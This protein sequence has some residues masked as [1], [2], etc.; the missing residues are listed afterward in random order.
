MTDASGP[1]SPEVRRGQWGE[2]I[3]WP[4]SGGML[5]G[6]IALVALAFASSRL[7]GGASP[8]ARDQNAMLQGVVMLAAFAVLGHYAWRAVSCTYPAERPVPWGGD[9]AEGSP[10]VRRVG[11]FAAAFMFS[12]MP[13]IAWL[14][15]RGLVHPAPWID[16]LVVAVLAAFGGAMLPLGLAGAV[17]RGNPLGATPATVRRMWRA[18]PYAARVAACA[19]LA[20]V[21]LLIA[22]TWAAQSGALPSDAYMPGEGPRGAKDPM[23]DGL[24]WTI[25]ALRGAGF[26]AALVS[27]RVAGLLVREVPAIR[28][29]VG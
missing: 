26:Y 1:S 2:V 4:L 22:S 16:T 18:E 25:F 13:L 10:L 5:G 11:A 27:F 14:W 3:R 8:S 7:E 9:D 12:F 24:K 19:S 23:G 20:F 21:G 17:V 6:V 29:V 15:T 28:E